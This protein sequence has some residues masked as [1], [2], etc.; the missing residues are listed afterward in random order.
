MT[1]RPGVTPDGGC[2]LANLLANEDP[3]G[4]AT[5]FDDLIL[6]RHPAPWARI[7]TSTPGLPGGMRPPIARAIAR[8]RR[9]HALLVDADDAAP[10]PD[11]VVWIEHVR[12][13]SGPARRFART[14]WH[15]PKVNLLEVLDELLAGGIPHGAEPLPV[16]TREMLVCTHGERDGC[17]GRFGEAAYRH[18]RGEHASPALR[19][20]RVS[21][22]G[23]H[24]FA[25]TLLDLP[26]ARSWGRLTTEALTALAQRAAS[27][28]DLAGHYRGWCAIPGPAQAAERDLFA[29]HGWA[30]REARAT[31]DLGEP[32]PTDDKARRVTLRYRLPGRPAHQR[33][34]TLRAR[35]SPSVPASCGAAASPI[36]HYWCAWDTERA[37][38][39]GTVAVQAE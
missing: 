16:P 14:A 34:A 3:I 31:V 23:G 2:A 11:G 29:E 25:P 9:V 21:H 6:L 28:A 7:A 33:T 32:A 15:V 26:D 13:R 18:L 20:W 17:C 35:P 39:A 8:G 1:G 10:A 27:P 36:D 22:F 30:W 24:R 4:T 19:I 12:R 38:A 5:P 37:V